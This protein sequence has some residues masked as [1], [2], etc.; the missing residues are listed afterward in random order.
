MPSTSKIEKSLQRAGNT[1]NFLGSWENNLT[2]IASSYTPNH[3]NAAFFGHS[4][5]R[6][7]L[8][9][10]L[11][12]ADRL[13][14]D[15]NFDLFNLICAYTE[16]AAKA[17]KEWTCPYKDMFTILEKKQ[18]H[19]SVNL[20]IFSDETSKTLQDC[21]Q[22][23]LNQ[24]N[25]QESKKK[26][27]NALVLGLFE[28][29]LEHEESKAIHAKYKKIVKRLIRD[30]DLEYT[31]ITTKKAENA[32][33]GDSCPYTI[34]NRING[35]DVNLDK[36]SFVR[37]YLWP[38]AKRFAQAT[39]FAYAAA[40]A[41]ATFF[42][43]VGFVSTA[44]GLSVLSFGSPIAIIVF[45]GLVGVAVIACLGFYHLWSDPAVQSMK[46]LLTRVP[47]LSRKQTFFWI[48]LGILSLCTAL[49]M[50]GVIAGIILT[51]FTGVGLP[52]VGFVLAGVLGLPGC[53]GLALVMMAVS[54]GFITTV[55]NRLDQYFSLWKLPTDGTNIVWHYTKA[56][57]ITLA[58]FS[59]VGLAVW[60]FVVMYSNP[61]FQGLFAPVMTYAPSGIE[62]AAT[63][64]FWTLVSLAM[65]IRFI[66]NVS[67]IVSLAIFTGKVITGSAELVV[68]GIAWVAHS[69]R[70]PGDTYNN[71]K[72]V[73]SDAMSTI[74][75]A[76]EKP[77]PL[78]IQAQHAVVHLWRAFKV[79]VA[80]F[81]TIVPSV[82]NMTV[83]SPEVPWH[84]NPDL[85]SVLE[86]SPRNFLDTP[87]VA[88]KDGKGSIHEL[89]KLG[90]KKTG[91]TAGFFKVKIDSVETP[92]NLPEN[93]SEEDL[94]LRG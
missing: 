91:N 38:F 33:N 73:F 32:I 16:L 15:I 55:S 61:W 21:M 14:H 31:I 35:H 24:S 13:N 53:I 5:K 94:S 75:H 79:T 20:A 42:G 83:D 66:Y 22:G 12:I 80:N 93:S 74:P 1:L 3:A 50:T 4:L 39:V 64:G 19:E 25:D 9:W 82:P 92:K 45:V 28:G 87:E 41:I 30:N 43:L 18:L 37:K 49:V 46:D 76:W 29:I 89:A 17:E 27:L 23:Y 34:Y 56:I 40:I 26:Y 7:R 52:I 88:L 63:I 57:V 8:Q 10:V 58:I 90:N 86:N 78:L 59:I 6:F 70:H 47:D 62:L 48:A 69:I 2:G 60:A 44:F 54:K 67:P 51:A 36:K 77:M 11:K 85:A 84:R 68:S 72:K 65:P 81:S 71:L